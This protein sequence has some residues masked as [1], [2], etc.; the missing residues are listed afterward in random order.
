[1]VLNLNNLKISKDVYNL[2]GTVSQFA[3]TEKAMYIT[4]P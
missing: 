2:F 3:F 4:V 1:M